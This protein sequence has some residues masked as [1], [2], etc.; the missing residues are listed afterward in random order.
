VAL[1]HGHHRLRR[2]QGGTDRH[3]VQLC[4][5]CHLGVVHAYPDWAYRHR[6]L[7]H[8]WSTDDG[9]P[10]VCDLDCTIDHTTPPEAA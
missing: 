6:W 2:S 1:C 5:N 4:G 10:I 3:V 8:A 7:L 9:P